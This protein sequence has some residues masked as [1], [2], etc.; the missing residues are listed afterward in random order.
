MKPIVIDELLKEDHTD[1]ETSVT[2]NGKKMTG[3]QLAKPE[4]YRKEYTPFIER[5]IGA[6]KVFQCKAIPVQY[7]CDLT[8]EE[9][10]EFVKTQL[11]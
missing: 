11:K 10:V 5:L 6:W 4:N 8:Q 2:I 1:T 9:Q 3:W 7:F